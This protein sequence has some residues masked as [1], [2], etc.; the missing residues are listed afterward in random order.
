MSQRLRKRNRLRRIAMHADRVDRSRQGFSVE[1]DQR[2]RGKHA[3]HPRNR[4]ID[5]LRRDRVDFVDPL[6]NAYEPSET[7]DFDRALDLQ[8]RE[9][10]VRSA[11][12][13]LG[14]VLYRGVP[15]PALNRMP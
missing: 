9:E 11:L 6:D 8:D 2:V 3:S 10:Q 14:L 13:A 1:G 5:I 12:S 7:P 15:R 4:R